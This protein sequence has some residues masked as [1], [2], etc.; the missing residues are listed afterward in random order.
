MKIIAVLSWGILLSLLLCWPGTVEGFFIPNHSHS[1]STTRIPC[2][3]RAI[4][5]STSI[6][7]RKPKYHQSSLQSFPYPQGADDDSDEPKS[8]IQKVL[9][10]ASLRLQQA[11]MMVPPWMSTA[12]RIL[13]VSL[14]LLKL[15]E[16]I[17]F[18]LPFA[19]RY[20]AISLGIALYLPNIS[21]RDS[22]G[23]YEGILAS[24]LGMAASG[25]FIV[26]GL[27]GNLSIATLAWILQVLMFVDIPILV[28]RVVSAPLMPLAW[29]VKVSIPAMGTPIRRMFW[30]PS[31]CYGLTV[32]A[33]E[34]LA[35]LLNR[36]LGKSKEMGWEE[37]DEGNDDDFY[38][39]L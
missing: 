21:M 3:T 17:W 6:H 12:F 2:L 18:I 16:L 5:S 38:Y 37:D 34:G 35:N 29:L 4:S 9:S 33:I 23:A 36:L 20:F 22:G 39:S 30:L 10:R 27:M 7:C 15:Q 31:W 25:L 11:T 28:K 1:S 14:V 26:S 13:A 32:D 8:V 24:R 19:S